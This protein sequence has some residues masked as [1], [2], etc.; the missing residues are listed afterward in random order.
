MKNGNPYRLSLCIE[1]E[2][3][4]NPAYLRE[5]ISSGVERLSS[6]SR[7]Q[8][9]ASPINKLSDRQLD[10]LTNLDGVDRVACC[11]YT[12]TDEGERGIGLARY[13]RLANENNIAEFAMTV[14]DEFQGQSI[15]YALLNKLIETA[16]DN[17]IQILRGM[18]LPSNRPMLSLC[19]RFNAKISQDDSFLRA[20]ITV[21]EYLA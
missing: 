9:F 21:S 7:W 6:Q 2:G 10:Y 11:A 13:V 15:G 17:S 1:R 18:V 8:R 4:H 5:Q 12:Q 19:K 3:R 16:G 20:D 14:V